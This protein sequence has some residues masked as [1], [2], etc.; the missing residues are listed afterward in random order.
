MTP[1]LERSAEALD[2]AGDLGCRNRTRAHVAISAALD[3]TEMV[4]AI[5]QALADSIVYDGIPDD[6]A[7]WMDQAQVAA[8]AVHDLILGSARTP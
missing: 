5:A 1:A 7:L 3:E 6:P 8:R 2:A 4:A